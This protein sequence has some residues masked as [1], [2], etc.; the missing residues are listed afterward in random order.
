MRKLIAAS[1]P[2][3]LPHPS[4]TCCG[5]CGHHSQRCR[6][7]VSHGSLPG[8]C[9]RERELVRERLEVCHGREALL[10]ELLLLERCE[11]SREELCQ[12]GGS[13]CSGC[14]LYRELHQCAI[15]ELGDHHLLSRGLGG[16]EVLLSC[17]LR[18]D[19]RSR[20][21]RYFRT[22]EAVTAISCTA[23]AIVTDLL[24]GIQRAVSAGRKG[25]VAAAG[26]IGSIG[27]ACPF[28]TLLTGI[29][30]AVSAEDGDVTA[31]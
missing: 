15:G 1:L 2:P 16:C 8:R 12:G 22:A 25:A 9:K 23:V 19:A 18:G 4:H 26:S 27:V 21:R 5:T 24:V 20:S 28:I 10:R 11:L 29:H 6:A 7:G 13:L 30:L 3:L 14:P 17:N 31:V